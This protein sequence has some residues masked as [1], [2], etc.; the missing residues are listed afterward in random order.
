[1]QRLVSTD[2]LDIIPIPD[3]D[4]S[5]SQPIFPTVPELSM[6][7]QPLEFLNE[8]LRKTN[9]KSGV[10]HRVRH[11]LKPYLDPETITDLWAF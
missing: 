2:F 4:L 6:A 10:V 5:G 8:E 11:D 3:A 9:G 7:R 1:M